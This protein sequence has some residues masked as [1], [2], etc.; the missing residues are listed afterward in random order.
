MFL[1]NGFVRAIVCIGLVLS[2]LM[3]AFADTIRLKNG[4][5]IKGR[6]TGF[7]GG[8]FTIAVG[9]GSRRRE[10][11]FDADEVESIVFS[12]DDALSA[13]ASKNPQVKEVVI[14]S[15]QTR[16]STPRVITTETTR[17]TPTATPAVRPAAT[18]SPT[19]QPTPRQI[20]TV[21]T[22]TPTATTRQ[23][24]PV[25][26]GKPVELNVRVLADNTANGWTNSGW[27]VKRGQKIKITG[28]GEVSLGRG[29]MST[30]AGL[31]EVEDGQKLMPNVPT[32][33]LLA[34]IGDDNN[35]FI[36][37]GLEREIIAE[38][39]GT[40]FLGINEGNLNDN[41]GSLDVKIEIS[42]GS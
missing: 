15:P 27:V 31:Y 17:P 23:N 1:N 22:R 4:S 32:G 24:P 28:N 11:S 2:M 40:L 9:D 29:R 39:D 35:D 38:R 18:P 19:V 21:S 14:N 36:Y 33:A 30:A 3:V 26:P 8:K 25:S 6:I 41:S 5:I 42:V 34:V 13:A 16:R 12:G 10:F 20:P 37:I 7:S